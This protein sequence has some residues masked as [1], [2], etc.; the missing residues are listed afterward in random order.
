MEVNN[1]LFNDNKYPLPVIVPPNLSKVSTPSPTSSKLSLQFSS[2][3]NY[4]FNHSSYQTCICQSILEPTSVD[5]T[6]LYILRSTFNTIHTEKIKQ[7][8]PHSLHSFAI[9][10]N[11]QQALTALL[12]QHAIAT[13]EKE[14]IGLLTRLL[15]LNLITNLDQLE[16]HH[17]NQKKQYRIE[18]D[19]VKPLPSFTPSANYIISLQLQD[20]N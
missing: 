17:S 8:Y 14:A 19:H 13:S 2:G 15:H 4:Y 10:F 11:G 18:C 3:N 6:L 9:S 1:H 16:A 12:Q 5:L 20:Q 7:L